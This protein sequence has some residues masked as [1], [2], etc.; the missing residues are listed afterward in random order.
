M[1]NSLS[2]ICTKCRAGKLLDDFHDDPRGRLGKQSRCKLCQQEA[3]KT[4]RRESTD[5]ARVSMRKTASKYKA[6][7]W[8][9]DPREETK[10]RRCPHCNQTKPSIAFDECHSTADGLQSWCRECSNSRTGVK[11]IIQSIKSRAKKRGI[12]FSLVESDIIIP[13]ECP[14]LGIPIY[15]MKGKPGPNSP[16]IDRVDNSKGYTPDNIQVISYRANVLKN[17]G[18]IDEVRRVL[19]YM[20]RFA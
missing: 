5:A 17:N 3:T 14:V 20:E 12:K 10:T 7:W 15:N 13:D 2:K 16:S 19:A 18:T 6:Y 4:W 1:Q 11:T 9:N 8:S